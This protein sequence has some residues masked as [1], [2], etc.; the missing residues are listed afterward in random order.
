MM[1]R[2]HVN[3]LI[4][5]EEYDRDEAL[6][7]VQGHDRVELPGLGAEEDDAAPPANLENFTE[8]Y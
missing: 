3:G 1:G 2:G 8:A 4:E 5:G 7:V 6:A